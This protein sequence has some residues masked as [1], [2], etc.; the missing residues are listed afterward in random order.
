VVNI[1]ADRYG[2][3]VGI[4]HLKKFSLNEELIAVGLHTVL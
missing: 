3:T 4:V 1:D 2:Q